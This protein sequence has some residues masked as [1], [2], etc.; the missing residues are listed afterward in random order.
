[1]YP[2][3]KKVVQYISILLLTFYFFTLTQ[4]LFQKVTDLKKEVQDLKGVNNSKDKFNDLLNRLK[5]YEKSR[6]V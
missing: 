1:M 2:N 4:N 6:W 3:L 5:Q